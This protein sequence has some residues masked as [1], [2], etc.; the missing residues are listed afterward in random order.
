MK[1]DN[2]FV[3]VNGA[4]LHLTKGNV[5]A[6]LPPVK[7]AKT[8]FGLLESGEVVRINGSRVNGVSIPRFLKDTGF[9]LAVRGDEAAEKLADAV[10]IQDG[11][12]LVQERSH[13]RAL[14]IERELGG[15]V[16][17]FVPF[18]ETK[19]LASVQVEAPDN[20][21][22]AALDRV[23]GFMSG[24]VSTK[25]DL[26]HTYGNELAL[27]DGWIVGPDGDPSRMA[28]NSAYG[29]TIERAVLSI[30]NCGLGTLMGAEG[31]S[32]AEQ[33]QFPRLLMDIAL[34]DGDFLRVG[35]DGG[36]QLEVEYRRAGKL[37]YSR[38]G[39]TKP[40]LGEAIGCI[41]AAM[42]RVRE[43]DA[44][45]AKKKLKKAA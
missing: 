19:P 36:D 32:A 37:L 40:R 18:D 8:W 9:E 25:F 15:K 39:L 22:S 31:V 30:C 13:T 29:G 45:P 44:Q 41:A 10:A 14:E 4:T 42:V 6:A 5:I 27:I 7:G 43:L 12:E 24:A 28:R 38:S 34:D 11:I 23:N 21:W 2:I 17:T 16:C 26:S 20:I 3:G 33:T 1:V 35:V